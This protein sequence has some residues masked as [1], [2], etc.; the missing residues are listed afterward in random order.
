LISGG[1]AF[2]GSCAGFSGPLVPPL[3]PLFLIVCCD[4]KSIF[5]R[6][7]NAQR[8]LLFSWPAAAG[9]MKFRGTSLFITHLPFA[10]RARLEVKRE[11][12]VMKRYVGFVLLASVAG[13]TPAVVAA[14][15]AAMLAPSS[16]GAPLNLLTSP[17]ALCDAESSDFKAAR[18]CEVR[19]AADRRAREVSRNEVHTALSEQ[20]GTTAIPFTLLIPAQYAPGAQFKCAPGVTSEEC[21]RLKQRIPSIPD[22]LTPPPTPVPPVIPP[23]PV[24]PEAAPP[25]VATDPESIIRPPRTGDDDLVRR[26]PPSGS[27]MPVIVPQPAPPPIP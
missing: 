27:Q 6:G 23:T 24:V 17:S 20:R 13:F 7:Y 18:I 2:A 21:E 1:G 22:T 9:L 4:I 15:Y 25:P 19:L 8:H 12:V 3:S 14:P 26:P 5:L 10:G 11:S 16:L